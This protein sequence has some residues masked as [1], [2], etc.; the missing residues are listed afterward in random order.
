MSLSHPTLAFQIDAGEI[1]VL[2][3]LSTTLAVAHRENRISRGMAPF[4]GFN[5]GAGPG[6]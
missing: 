2:P 5:R 1:I 4:T 3:E 6:H